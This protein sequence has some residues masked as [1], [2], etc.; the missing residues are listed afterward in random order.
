MRMYFQR[1][2]L[3]WYAREISGKLKVRSRSPPNS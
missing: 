1:S 2:C 3:P